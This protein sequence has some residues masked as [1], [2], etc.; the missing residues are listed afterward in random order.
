MSEST[1]TLSTV[2][3]G[4]QKKEFEIPD[5]Q[6]LTKVKLSRGWILW[7][8]YKVVVFLP[9]SKIRNNLQL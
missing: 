5:L 8:G 9:T 1:A 2:T 7:W 3:A 4:N 6:L